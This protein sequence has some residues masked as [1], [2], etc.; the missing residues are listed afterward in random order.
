M[1]QALIRR[2]VREDAGAIAFVRVVGWRQS[3]AGL[4][5][6]ELLSRLDIEADKQRVEK[7]FD[8]P[9]NSALRFVAEQQKNIVAMGV[10]GAERSGED[11]MCGE[12]YALY[13]LDNVKRRGIGSALM[14]AMAQA[15]SDSG[16]TS[17]QLSVLQNNAPARAFYEK[18][19]GKLLKRGSFRYE[20][21]E[22]PD[23]NY[24]WNDLDLLVHKP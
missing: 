3:Y 22:L 16:F 24:V 4:M 12:I 9:A 18:L 21:H 14:K 6:L 11:S 10:C 8:D 17:L 19:G 13:L 2:A 20:G 7:A 1:E 15:L 23:V 5:P